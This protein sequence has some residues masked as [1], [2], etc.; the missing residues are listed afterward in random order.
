VAHICTFFSVENGFYNWFIQ[1]H[2][3][4]LVSPERVYKLLNL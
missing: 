2:C 4:Q 1:L 3:F